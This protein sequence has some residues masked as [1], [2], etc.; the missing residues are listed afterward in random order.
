[1]A[2]LNSVIRSLR[3]WLLASALFIAS[4]TFAAPN[5]LRVE[6]ET[7]RGLQAES[8]TTKPPRHPAKNTQRFD[9]PALEV[10][11][12]Q[13]QHGLHT[14]GVP[15]QVG[16]ARE[17]AALHSSARMQKAVDWEALP[18]GGHVAA[19]AI[20]AGNARA[21]RLGIRVFSLPHELRLRILDGRQAEILD[22]AGAAVIRQL[23][24]NQEAGE[25]TEAARTWWSPVVEG[26]RIELELEIPPGIRPDAVQ[27]AIPFISHLAFSPETLNNVGDALPCHNDVRCEPGWSSASRSTVHMV[28]T[29]SSGNSY[30]CTGTLLNDTDSRTSIPYLLS[31][32][33]CFSTQTAASSL[34]TYW[35][36][37]ASACDTH[38]LYD[39]YRILR[40]GADL[41]YASAETD[42]LFLRLKEAPP[43]GAVFA[44][45]QT[46]LPTQGAGIVGIHHPQGD[47]QKISFGAVD[48]YAA[49][50]D[51]ADGFF[52]C[53]SSSSA[54]ANHIKVTWNSGTTEGGSSGS[55]LFNAGKYV[56][57]TLHGGTPFATCAG[58]DSYY[59]RFDLPF[60]LKLHEYLAP[61]LDT[62]YDLAIS[63]LG[64]GSGTVRGSGIDCGNDCAETYPSG[65]RVTLLQTPGDNSR[66]DGW[67]GAC[68][69]PGDSCSFVMDT[70]RQV[71]ARYTRIDQLTLR[72]AIYLYNQPI[73]ANAFKALMGVNCDAFQL[74]LDVT[75][76]FTDLVMYESDV[77]FYPDRIWSNAPMFA[78]SLYGNTESKS[79]ALW[80]NTVVPDSQIGN[81]TFFGYCFSANPDAFVL[82]YDD[83]DGSCRLSDNTPVDCSNYTTAI[84]EQVSVKRSVPTPHNVFGK[85]RKSAP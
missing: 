21:I 39:G 25:Y 82:F 66:F 48:G 17:V 64:S 3:G 12:A 50:Y 35:F 41:L 46:T 20:D 72:D 15:L 19:I 52:Y 18:G 54:S 74:M 68:T 69:G 22:I 76:G 31:A 11:A 26:S 42:T 55:A 5:V 56:I 51:G 53:N 49:C 83:A 1:M 37:Y 8:A 77:Y 36:F 63:V 30:L 70:S 65:T 47:L 57:G 78:Y 67:E 16:V 24:T 60:R 62:S 6:P 75:A 27:F 44:G 81:A 34:Q 80:D 58:D 79:F 4:G 43:T 28:Y 33:H 9:L 71:I 10:S 23:Q 59:G 73:Q 38:Q 45:W 85:I 14:P 2:L 13:M 61:S 32:N 84:R 40:G 7:A 29:E